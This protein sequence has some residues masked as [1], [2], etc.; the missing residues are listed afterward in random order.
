VTGFEVY[1][2]Y[3]S[4]KLHFTSK[5][6]DY[7][8]YGNSAKASP[9]AFDRR[10][11]KYFFV[12]L[13]RKFKEPELRDFFVSNMVV[14]GGQW[15]GQITRE[16]SRHYS[17]YIKKMQSLAYLFT[18]DV[19]TLHNICDRFDDLFK[20]DTVHPPIV[21]AYLGGKISLETLTIFQQIFGFMDHLKVD[22]TVVWE[23]LKD[24]VK[25]YEPFLAADI[26][27]YK[28]IIQREFL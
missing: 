13:S 18:Q 23:P 5:T 10:K 8:K 21:K 26:I 2:M 19:S 12:K 3:L 22:D 24:R 6:F 9:E 11:D 15:V 17:D 14:D 16:G 25:K 1:K 7:F 20:P 4:L 27:K 28:K